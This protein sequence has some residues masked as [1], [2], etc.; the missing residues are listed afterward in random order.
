MEIIE[1]LTKSDSPTE[2]QLKQVKEAID[3]PINYDEDCP[4]TDDKMMKAFILAAKTRDR[5]KA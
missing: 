3:K 1:K 5:L 4:E 2:E